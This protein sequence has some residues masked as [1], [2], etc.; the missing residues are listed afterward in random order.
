MLFSGSFYCLVVCV[1]GWYCSV[2]CGCRVLSSLTWE[3]CLGTVCFGVSHYLSDVCKFWSLFVHKI[4]CRSLIRLV[5]GHLFR[6]EENGLTLVFCLDVEAT[7]FP[8]VSFSEL[9]QRCHTD[10]SEHATA[11]INIVKW[12]Y[13]WKYIHKL[14]IYIFKYTHFPNFYSQWTFYSWRWLGVCLNVLH[15]S[16]SVFL[17]LRN[18]LRFYFAILSILVWIEGSEVR[19]CCVYVALA[20]LQ[21]PHWCCH[22]SGVSSKCCCSSQSNIFPWKTAL[23]L[24]GK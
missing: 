23:L 8:P 13:F 19:G 18:A 15:C 4:Q 7:S 20:K 10:W 11:D 22:E 5:C 6:W 21:R 17:H 12:H 2:G 16:L 3:V 1:L 24:L 9:G 14:Y